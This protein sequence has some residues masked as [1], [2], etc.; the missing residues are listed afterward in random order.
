VLFFLFVSLRLVFSRFF[1]VFFFFFFFWFFLKVSNLWNCSVSYDQV[2]QAIAF[3]NRK[4]CIH[5]DIKSDN[6]LLNHRGEVKLAD[7]GFAV[8][9]EDFSSRRETVVGTPYW[10][11]PV[12]AYNVLFCFV[13]IYCF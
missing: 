2:L 12:C 3:M 1:F 11:A 8:Q 10:M 4:N 9:M 7:F 6:I 13:I 5:R